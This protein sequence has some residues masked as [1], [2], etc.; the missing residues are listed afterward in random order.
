[1]AIPITSDSLVLVLGVVLAA[2]YLY[3]DQ[4]FNS[5]TKPKTTSLP[6]KEASGHGNPR[7]FVA[8]MKAGVG[9]FVCLVRT[10]RLILCRKNALSSSMVHKLG[11][12]KNTPFVSPRRPNP[13]LASLPLFVT[14]K[15]MISR[16]WM[17]FQR[18][19]PQFS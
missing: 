14:P 11:Q 16:I 12:P 3:R 10:I 19:V 17:R 1:M 13:S 2:L 6:A 5:T 9:P 4:V 18:I 15:N 8:K 7:D